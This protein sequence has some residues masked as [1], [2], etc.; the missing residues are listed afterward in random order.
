MPRDTGKDKPTLSVSVA[1]TV[2]NEGATLPA[3]ISTLLAQTYPPAEVVIC[4]GGSS[5]NTWVILEELQHRSQDHSTPV[6]VI[7]RP[8]ANISEGRNAAIRETHH[9]FIAVTDSGIRLEPDW[10]EQMVRVME[11][12]LADPDVKGVAGFFLPEA[13]GAF[14]TA[15]AGTTMPFRHDVDAEKFLPAGRSM[16]FRRAVW[17]EVGGF[18]EWL[19]YC[20]DLVF[21]QQVEH[22]AQGRRKAMPLA[23]FSVVRVRPRANY[24]SFY[25]QYFLYARGDGKADLWGK[26]H[27]VR[28]AV[29]LGLVPLL[30]GMISGSGASPGLG[31]IPGCAGAV[32]VL[33]TPDYARMEAGAVS[34]GSLGNAVCLPADSGGPDGGRC[35][36]D[37]GISEWMEMAGATLDRA[38]HP[39]AHEDANSGRRQKKVRGRG[40]SLK[41]GMIPH[42]TGQCRPAL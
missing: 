17:E 7:S 18:P 12:G 9:E 30:A 1:M 26:R 16:L 4:D 31:Q 34:S 41:P 19:D 8:G 35:R 3:F 13:V 25:R 37:D 32:R 27:L 11:A 21:D 10:L 42:A 29:Y 20:E 14:E 2:L 36:Q 5:D 33:S 38:R 22:L 15:L 23:E 24:R 6:R 28:Y 39:L 40:E